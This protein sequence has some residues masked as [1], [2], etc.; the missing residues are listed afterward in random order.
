[1]TFKKSKL[2]ASLV[3][4]NLLSS[5][6]NVNQIEMAYDQLRDHL[7][8]AIASVDGPYNPSDFKIDKKHLYRLQAEVEKNLVW[9]ND[10]AS[11]TKSS[12]Q[13][14]LKFISPYYNQNI[15]IT[16]SLNA[17]LKNISW[18]VDPTTRF[19]IRT[20][21]ISKIEQRREIYF[22][23]NRKLKRHERDV[24]YAI[25]NPYDEIGKEIIK[26]IKIGLIANI[27]IYEN[28]LLLK[29]KIKDTVSQE[30]NPEIKAKLKNYYDN[31]VKKLVHSPSHIKLANLVAIYRDFKI[32]EQVKAHTKLAYYINPLI[33][34]TLVYNNVEKK[35]SKDKRWNPQVKKIKE[36]IAQ[37][38]LDQSFN[39]TSYFNRSMK[40]E[41]KSDG[42]VSKI[43]KNEKKHLKYQ[44]MPMDIIFTHNENSFNNA[45]V[46]RFWDNVGVWVG[47]WDD[48][49][50]L[51]LSM[52]PNI[53]K[54]R[55]Q[56]E[57]QK[58]SFLTATR[59]GV[60]L[61]PLSFVLNQDD[62]AVIRKRHYSYEQKV[63]GLSLA[64]NDIGKPYN[65]NM[66]PEDKKKT[67]FAQLV[68]NI[69]PEVSWDKSYSF[70]QEALSPYKITQRTGEEREFFTV[71]LYRNG[72]EVMEDLED[73]FRKLS[74]EQ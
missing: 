10:F 52:H 1:M 49:V 65:F 51:G 30:E 35:F 46:E 5:C 11:A 72:S 13:D 36:V 27:A 48:I 40:F 31:M 73:N 70:K 61:K 37:M 67:S 57:Q 58:L 16:K 6:A 39:Y 44:L 12:Q 2:M 25:I 47:S 69:Y 23:G 4:V 62:I 68:F 55:E 59:K 22:T 32:L 15:E 19:E 41:N 17:Y 74:S 28:H 3:I 29:N 24:D 43:Y 26:A 56:I 60:E 34:D 20:D 66:N 71:L 50:K 64:F 38:A 45:V 21:Q 8:R 33:E 42:K 63:K 18:I 54:Y 14:S 53:L 9:R 7:S